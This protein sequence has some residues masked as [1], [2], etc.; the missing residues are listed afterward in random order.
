[1]GVAIAHKMPANCAIAHDLWHDAARMKRGERWQMAHSD[2]LSKVY[3]YSNI[4]PHAKAVGHHRQSMPRE[5]KERN[6]SAVGRRRK[7]VI[8]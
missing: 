1:M 5:N 4:M 7:I 8:A 6:A 2:I 3:R